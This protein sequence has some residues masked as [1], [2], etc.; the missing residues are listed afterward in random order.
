MQSANPDPS[1][2][3]TSDSTPESV[4]QEAEDLANDVLQ[5]LDK[6]GVAQTVDRETLKGLMI[7]FSIYLVNRDYKI[8]QHGI[9]LGK[10]SLT[11]DGQGR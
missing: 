8:L 5:I 2:G 4:K 6:H 1:L 10:K 11:R 9:E 3:S 7:D